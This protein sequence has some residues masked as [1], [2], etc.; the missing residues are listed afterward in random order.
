MEHDHADGVPG[1]RRL[2]ARRALRTTLTLVILVAAYLLAYAIRFEF[3]IPPAFQRTAALTVVPVVSLQY[4]LLQLLRAHRHSWR[5]TSLWD[6]IAV[7]EA[8]SASALV[9]AGARVVSTQVEVLTGVELIPVIPWGVLLA[10]LALAILG[11][12]GI[13]TVRRVQH[14]QHETRVLQD[15][16]GDPRRTRVILLGAGRAGAA[17]ARELRARPDLKMQAVGF[18]D[19]DP[20]KH[21]QVI[22]GLEVLGDRTRLADVVEEN[23]I[24]EAIITIA[25]PSGRLV[26]EL[27]ELCRAAGI[28]V[29]IVPGVHEL[30]GG[31]VT[32]SRLRRVDIEDLLRREPAE[33]DT[34]AIAEVIAG[35]PVLVTGAG[36]SI[37]AELCRQL[38]R[39]APSSLVLVER[40]EPA[41]WAIH[42]DLQA[43]FPELPVVP[44]IADV[45]DGE[46]LRGVLA[47][48]T[49]VV[50]FHAAA[51][52][53]VPMMELNP[54]EAVKNNV[55]GTITVVDA[56]EELG[57]ERFV[58]VSTDKA[59]NPTSVMGA[60]KRV[61]ER[62]VQHVAAR[63]GRAYVS[64]RFGNVLGSTGSVVPV[65]R[66]QI[67]AGGPV[68]VTHPDMRRYFMTIPEASALV[69]Q[70][71]VL[72]TGGEVFVLEMGEP[73]RIV[74]LARDLIRLSGLD[75]DIDIRI[76]FSGVRPG[77]K[78][79]EEL[80]FDAEDTDV[81]SHPSIAISTSA[82]AAWPT[83]VEDLARLRRVLDG[84]GI[85]EVRDRL[86]AVVPE[87]LGAAEAPQ[88][89]EAARR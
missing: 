9:L 23:A 51:H 18:L 30:L 60:T 55:F 19:D 82:T 73:V 10:N 71:A 37:G 14:E 6:V 49:P 7:V 33:L 85:E 34:S 79:Y 25:E 44:V 28:G 15:T 2:R 31:K 48:T 4:L 78:L 3:A 26:R 36:G 13:R 38:G 5:F 35:R 58:L 77:E 22:H 43:A 32:L 50:V 16:V 46:R 11:L 65:F 52:K 84:A 62:Y 80:S 61:A 59:V 47:A 68:T 89:T 1:H 64:V 42:R 54:G 12:V 83:V 76:E 27:T 45:C 57:V 88:V 56:C 81:T 72:G 69:V 41:L 20:A 39:F 74:D 17:I 66:Q 21:R 53:H 75:P 87:L 67:E 63:S 8:L 86:A 70:A 40:A 29:R 24:D